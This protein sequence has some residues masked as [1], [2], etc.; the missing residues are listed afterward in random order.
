MR[1]NH[2]FQLKMISINFP[3]FQN[4]KL[5]TQQYHFEWNKSGWIG[6]SMKKKTYPFYNHR[7][8][9][10]SKMNFNNV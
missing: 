6:L 7:M 10:Y 4:R 5:K 2:E 8:N 9:V 3:F 1:L